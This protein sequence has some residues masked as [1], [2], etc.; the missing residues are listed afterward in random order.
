[1]EMNAMTIDQLEQVAGGNYGEYDEIASLIQSIEQKKHR[2][3][4][5]ML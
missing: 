5:P 1:M 4:G 2:L 3:T